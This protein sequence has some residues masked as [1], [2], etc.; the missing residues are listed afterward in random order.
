MKVSGALFDR[1]AFDTGKADAQVGSYDP[2]PSRHSHTPRWA[3]LGRGGR[4]LSGGGTLR[5]SLKGT[6]TFAGRSTSA[7]ADWFAP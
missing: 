5:Q 2:M 1:A 4:I 7:T 6:F 3:T